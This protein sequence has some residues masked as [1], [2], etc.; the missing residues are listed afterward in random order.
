MTDI[1]GV[2]RALEDINFKSSSVGVPAAPSLSSLLVCL[3]VIGDRVFFC[4]RLRFLIQ[5]PVIVV[6]VRRS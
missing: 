4:S 3:S 5:V 2:S 1:V 6:K